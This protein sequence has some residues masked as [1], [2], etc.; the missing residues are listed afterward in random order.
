MDKIFK[1]I[2]QKFGRLRAVKKAERKY[3]WICECSCGTRKEIR[4]YDLLNGQTK[5]CGCLNKEKLLRK[6]TTHGMTNTATYKSWCG[7]K[8]RCNNPRDAAYGRYGG[9]GIKVCP[10][11]LQFE[12]FFEDM[13][14]KP[15]KLTLERLDNNKGY[16]PDN[17]TWATRW[18]QNRN[19]KNNRMYSYQGEAKCLADWAIEMGMNYQTLCSRLNKYPV[20]IAFNM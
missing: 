15:E 5:S 11:W 7:M 9:R 1:L 6:V 12:N 3:Y 8:G 20:E 10:R 13:G 17:C 18:T 4:G 19:K 2:N 16:S 14:E